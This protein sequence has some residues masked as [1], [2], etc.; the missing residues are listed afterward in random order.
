MQLYFFVEGWKCFPYTISVHI[1][2]DEILASSLNGKVLK[3]I[4]FPPNGKCWHPQKFSLDPTELVFNSPPFIFRLLSVFNATLPQF[5]PKL[6]W[7][8]SGHWLKAR[9][10]V[11]VGL[12]RCWALWHLWSECLREDY[13]CWAPVFQSQPQNERLVT[14][15]SKLWERRAFH[16]TLHFISNDLIHWRNQ[17]YYLSYH[18]AQNVQTPQLITVQ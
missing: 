2:S 18:R 6:T 5:H 11:C 12:R 4:F 16:T 7:Q 13:P 9:R 17:K 10:G 14:L 8:C 3:D 1:C 15:W